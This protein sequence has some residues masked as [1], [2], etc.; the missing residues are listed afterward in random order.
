MLLTAA[1]VALAITLLTGAGLLL[2]SFRKVV[3]VD[4]GYEKGAVLTFEMDIP[5]IKYRDGSSDGRNAPD[6]TGLLY[7]IENTTDRGTHV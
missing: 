5:G 2:R 1:Q 4:L 6:N 7:R 3:A